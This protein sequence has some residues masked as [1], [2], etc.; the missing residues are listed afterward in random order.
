M[1]Q[2]EP[3]GTSLISPAAAGA[4]LTVDLNTIRENYRR[5]KSRLGLVVP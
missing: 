1:S 3:N 2:H 5:L 4:I